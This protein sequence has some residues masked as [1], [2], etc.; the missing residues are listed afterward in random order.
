MK[1]HWSW[2]ALTIFT[3]ALV[4]GGPAN[5]TGELPTPSQILRDAVT[6][7]K[8]RRNTGEHFT[9]DLGSRTGKFL[10]L[11]S[12]IRLVSHLLKIQRPSWINGFTLDCF[13]IF[14]SW[15]QPPVS[16]T[17]HEGSIS[18]LSIQILQL[19]KGGQPTNCFHNS[20]SH[21]WIWINCFHLTHQFLEHA[22]CG[23]E[24]NRSEEWNLLHGEGM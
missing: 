6:K 2:V 8:A 1:L 13:H 22:V 23:Y 17:P 7:Y 14:L 3:I 5:D 16:Q 19:N 15:H 12:V 9:D 4:L 20:F 11:F 24:R 18:H 21:S 10:N